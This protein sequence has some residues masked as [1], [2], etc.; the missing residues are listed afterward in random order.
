MPVD[1]IQ[2]PQQSREGAALAAIDAVEARVLRDQEQLLR[3]PAASASASATIDVARPA[4]IVAAKRRD[5]AERA[6]VVA[7]LGDLDVRVVTGRGQQAR[8]VGVVDVGRQSGLTGPGR[9][10]LPVTGGPQAERRV[11]SRRFRSARADRSR[12]EKARS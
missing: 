4:A 5:D 1:A 10:R 3:P 12:A 8:R 7:A 11:P 6:L 2:R 9:N